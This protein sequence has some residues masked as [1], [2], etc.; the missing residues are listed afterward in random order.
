[1]RNRHIGDFSE[2]DLIRTYFLPFSDGLDDDV[3]RLKH[4]PGQELLLSTD[5]LQEGIHFLRR[6]PARLIGEKVVRVNASDIVASGGVPRWLALSLSLPGKLEINWLGN[7]VEGLR[8]AL[9]ETGMELVGGDTT[10]AASHISICATALGTVPRGRSIPRS[11]ARAGDFIGVTGYLGEATP[12]LDVILGKRR[13]DADITEYW[14]V[15]HFIPPFRGHFGAAVSSQVTAM[16]DLSDGVATDLPRLC[17]VSGVRAEVELNAL[18]LSPEALGVGLTPEQAFTGAEDYELLFTVP[19]SRWRALETI[20]QTCGTK[21]TRIGF[22]GK[23][24]G[25]RILKG[26]KPVKHPVL[27]PWKHFS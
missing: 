23:G 27:P 18:P 3:A 9:E 5:A 17:A 19:P 2:D 25:L 22:L 8:R 15:R 10:A 11:G 7:F 4:T 24:R 20:A 21:I 26:G 14:V 1:M 6:S 16:M 13:F 12:G